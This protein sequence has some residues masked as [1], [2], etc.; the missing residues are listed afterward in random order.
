M[1]VFLAR[2]RG[3]QREVCFAE[4]ILWVAAG[5]HDLHPPLHAESQ[6]LNRDRQQWEVHSHTQSIIICL[7]RQTGDG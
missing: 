6:T 3:G 5:S 1:G 2:L 7:S 4:G